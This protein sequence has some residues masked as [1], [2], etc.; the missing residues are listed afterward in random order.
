VVL[1]AVR[2]SST[3]RLGEV[4]RSRGRLAVV[5]V[6]SAANSV[7]NPTHQQ[8]RGQGPATMIAAVKHGDW[9]GFNNVTGLLRRRTFAKE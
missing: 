5:E 7:Q 1:R 2:K 6:G 3:W 9:R 8:F 4:Q